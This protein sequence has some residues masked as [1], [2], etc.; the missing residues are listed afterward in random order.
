MGVNTTSDA[1]QVGLSSHLSDSNDVAHSNSGSQSV[2]KQIS[3]P[4]DPPCIGIVRCGSRESQNP[5]ANAILRQLNSTTTTATSTSTTAR[6]R[7]WCTTRCRGGCHQ[8]IGPSVAQ[9]LGSCDAP[10]LNR[11]E[12]DSV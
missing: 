12:L 9:E 11:V 10:T 2:S 8:A 3:L 1:R 7:R 6:G 4:C 5:V